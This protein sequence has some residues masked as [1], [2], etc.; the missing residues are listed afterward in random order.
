M[1]RLMMKGPLF[2]T[3]SFSYQA[4]SRFPAAWFSVGSL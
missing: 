3:R 4:L 1:S 2:R